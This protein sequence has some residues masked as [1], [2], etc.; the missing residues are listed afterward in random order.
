MLKRVIAI[1]FGLSALGFVPAVVSAQTA[2]ASASTNANAKVGKDAS[3]QSSTTVEAEL[4]AARKREL[5]EAPIRRRVAEGR[6]KGASE[7]Q[8][9]QA[10]RK[11]LLT[12]EAAV[13]AMAS[14]GRA[15]PT[16][17]EV[18]RATGAMERGYTRAQV[19]AVAKSAPSDRSLVVAFDVLTKLNERGVPVAKALAQVTSKLEARQPDVDIQTLLGAQAGA[20]I[21]VS[22][23]PGQASANGTLGTTVGGVIR[24]P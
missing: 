8:Q 23:P 3:V 14:G 17:E 22:K 24:K 1:G 13:E 6:A 20:G 9:A 21:G 15:H 12:M 4:T 7:A 18:D 19:E 2:T 5:P 11:V 16:D 10:A